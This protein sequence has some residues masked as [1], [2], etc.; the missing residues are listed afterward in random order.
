ME[1]KLETTSIKFKH[2]NGDEIIINLY[3]KFTCIIG[4]NSGEGKTEFYQQL[5][6]RELNEDIEIVADYNV[7]MADSMQT[8][9]DI[10]KIDT[11]S[12]IIV[13]ELAMIKWNIMDVI[14][15]SKHLFICI[16]RGL[17]IRLSYPYCG[18]YRL[19]RTINWFR[20]VNDDRLPVGNLDEI[21]DLI[22]TESSN[23]RSEHELFSIY[24]DNLYPCNS[25]DNIFRKLRKRKGKILVFVDLGNVGPAYLN[26]IRLSEINPDIRFYNYQCFEELLWYSPMVQSIK[27]GL[28]NSNLDYVTIEQYYESILEKRTKGTDLGYEHGKPLSGSFTDINNYR[29]IFDS[30]VGRE[31]MCYID[32]NTDVILPSKD[33]PNMEL[34]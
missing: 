23:N 31:L 6:Y 7:M 16:S 4:D 27:D 25:R 24:L 33:V 32:N 28:V 26:L 13:D 5:Y 12:I 11:K 30:G 20:I 3:S 1:N 15:N 34:F 17:P 9:V 29:K 21:Y 10:L 18:I 14:N 2:I 22:A 19:E 8:L